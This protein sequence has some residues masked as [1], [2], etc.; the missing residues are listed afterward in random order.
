MGK[1]GRF[2]YLPWPKGRTDDLGGGGFR[3]SHDGYSKLGIR[4][5]REVSLRAEGGFVV[6]D[7]VAGAGGRK[8]LW[9]WRL[10]D[11]PWKLGRE[12]DRVEVHSEGWNHAVRWRGP[13]GCRSRLLRGDEATSYGWWSPHYGAV[14]PAC[15][16]L[17]EADA[18]GDVELE[19]EFFPMD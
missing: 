17:I 6:R 12:S 9:Q 11:L 2:L 4:W 5:M 7:C 15:A 3:A 18:T 1:L 14:E 19:V 13:A 8:L 16:L 10:A